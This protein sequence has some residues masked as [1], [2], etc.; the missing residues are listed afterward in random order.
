MASFDFKDLMIVDQRPG[1]D[2]LTKYRR[3]RSKKINESTDL[4]ELSMKRDKKLP[5]LI[6]PVKGKKGISKI[7]D[8]VVAQMHIYDYNQNS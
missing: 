6:V 3:L 1:E 7:C 4:N 2:P 8:E 5:N